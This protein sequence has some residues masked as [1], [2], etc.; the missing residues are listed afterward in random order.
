MSALNN[1]KNVPS[2]SADIDLSPMG[3]S[4]QLSFME[5]DESEKC[6]GCNSNEFHNLLKNSEET[7]E[8]E[9]TTDNDDDEYDSE[10]DD[11]DARTHGLTGQGTAYTVDKIVAVRKK[12]KGQTLQW[13][14][15]WEEKE[16]GQYGKDRF[17]WEPSKNI[18]KK[19]REE[20][21][22]SWKEPRVGVS[23]GYF[24]NYSLTAVHQLF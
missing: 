7:D 14:I 9:S 8:T 13:Y 4:S 1:L 6:G 24:P 17:T 20:F 22:K 11:N 2:P 21:S 3:S 18:S 10:L 5:P 15:C 16:P 12:S 19:L 23:V